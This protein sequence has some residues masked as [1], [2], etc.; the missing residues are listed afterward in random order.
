[1]TLLDWL[2]LWCVV[3]VVLGVAMG[4][5]LGSADYDDEDGPA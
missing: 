5:I 4:A 3:S 2:A 1:M